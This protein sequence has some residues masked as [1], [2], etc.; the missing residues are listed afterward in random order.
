MLY[1][2]E[3][4]LAELK[5]VQEEKKGN[6][7][8][9]S[10]NTH[11][12]YFNDLKNLINKTAGLGNLLKEPFSNLPNTDFDWFTAPSQLAKNPIPAT[13]TFWLSAKF[14]KKKYSIPPAYSRTKLDE[15]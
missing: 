1:K 5:L 9:I 8:L 11:L 2:E 10:I 6:I 15:K 14:Q 7:T 4:N 3:K 13:W 12:P